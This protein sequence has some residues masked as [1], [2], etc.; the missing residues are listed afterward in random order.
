M[1]CTDMQASCFEV[2][3]QERIRVQGRVAPFPM[4]PGPGRIGP[5]IQTVGA[6]WLSGK[7]QPWPITGLEC[8]KNLGMPGS[9]PGCC[10]E[11]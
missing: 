6:L 11:Q 8:P 9:S 2:S 4:L 10:G 5:P 3:E 1:R 7:R